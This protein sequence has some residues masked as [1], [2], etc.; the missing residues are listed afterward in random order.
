MKSIDQ[1]RPGTV[2]ATIAA[3]LG[4]AFL[5]GYVAQA[6]AADDLD[7]VQV[8]G[9]RIKRT[10]DFDTA[11]PT[12]V[13]DADYL[14]QQGIVNVGDA[15]KSLPSNISNFSPTTTGNSNFFAGSTIANLRGLNPFFGS[16]TLNLVNGRRHV[17]TN[18]GDGVDL[19]FIPSILIDRMD[20]VT[21]GASAVYGSGAISGVNNLFLNRKLDGIKVE[22]DFGQSMHQDAR[23]R[24]YA[25]AF[26]T[27]FNNDRGHVTFAFE[28]QGMDALGCVDVRAWCAQNV[29][30]ITNP[31]AGSYSASLGGWSYNGALVSLSDA[32][33]SSYLRSNVRSPFSYAGVLQ[34]PGFLPFMT[35]GPVGQINNAGTALL[36]F[37][38]GVG[39]NTF[40]S[41]VSGGEGRP[42]Y[43]YTNLRSP[44]DRNVMSG[45]LT[46]KL[47]DTIN[48]TADASWGKVETD[49]R[50]GA[51]DD[52]GFFGKGLRADNAYLLQQPGLAAQVTPYLG[53]PTALVFPTQLNKD[54]ALQTNPHSAFETEVKRFSV[55]LDGR[56]G[57]TSWTWDG[58]YQWGRSERNQLVNDNRHLNAYDF[59]AD[60]VFSD[61]AQF[62]SL[63]NNRPIECRITQQIRNGTAT[64]ATMGQNLYNIAQ[65]CVP[66]NVLGTAALDPKAKAYA[67][68]FLNEHTT[69]DQ[70]VLAFNTTG[71]LH[72]GVGAGSIKGAAGV[73]YRQEKTS[74]I[75][76][77]NGAPDYVR[78][79]YLIQYGESFAG[80]VNVTEAYG[81][82][83]LPLLRDAAL[84]KRLEFDAAA[85]WSRYENEG[86]LGPGKGI[87]RSH[88]MTTWKVS[89][90]WD[91][92]DWL[93]IRGSQSRDSRAANARELYYG[94]IIQAG[95]W[96][97]YCT[98]AGVAPGSPPD[99]C[100]WSLEGNVDLKPEKA[101][102][103]TIGFVLTPRDVIPGFEFAMDY[104]HIKIT[105]A[106]Q[107]ANV[108]RVR[109]GCQISGIKAFCNLITPDP[110]ATASP[111]GAGN[112]NYNPANGTGIQLLRA[113]S[114]NG[115]M[116][117]YSG[118]DITS[119][120]RLDMGDF[121]GLN[122]RLLATRMFKQEF[123][124]VPGQAPV[125]ITGQTG[126][127]NSFLN[128]NNPSAKWNAQLS[129]TYL[130][131]AFSAT[132]SAHYVGEGKKNYLGVDPTDGDWY[133]KAPSNWVRLE[134]NHVP[135]YTVFGLN[136]NYR[137]ENVM[138][139][140]TVDLWANVSN[141]FDKDPPLIGGGSG[142]TQPIFFD[143]LG[144]YYKIGFR[145]SF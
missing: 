67:F 84:A 135:S 14:K 107:Q 139:A 106:I 90:I 12:T 92:V 32:H 11:N 112:Y 33:P 28:H 71:D 53:F 9:S 72:A 108:T 80:S 65:G 96:F 70:E 140:K 116:Y 74:N 128:D 143:T 44:V 86:T 133:I 42:A 91:P 138:G 62:A 98:P 6:V 1:S 38:N 93:R 2:R 109:E 24:H 123:S 118:L 30:L 142:G 69:Q 49:Q 75:G 79:D 18:Q 31:A 117:N 104:F 52:G 45:T 27:G 61:Q 101:D 120:Y 78:N 83:I 66:L 110:T 94:Q 97:G 26:G 111:N 73:E 95:G 134:D 58:Y 130:K 21:G 85:R 50:T 36:P 127:A 10:T 60:A 22:A 64:V 29:N 77:Q 39:S 105:D 122:F 81:E 5:G 63:G 20:V 15:V 87:S 99:A 43:Q 76:S 19:N 125:N 115:S 54:W 41:A 40:Y 3:I 23:D 114:F 103:T 8:T 35:Q 141:L 129:T 89:G 113:Q 136:G 102:T 145:A 13:V 37:Q 7:E 4:T 25:A 57:D 82:V 137:F 48:L 88:D 55:G 119:S 59:A 17:P 47:T 144:R 34:G 16:R 51:L 132:L 124:P 100:T 121:G 68:G 131:G 56:F 126:T 46:Y